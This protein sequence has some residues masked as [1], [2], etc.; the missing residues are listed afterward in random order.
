MKF[1][2]YF[3]IIFFFISFMLALA[4]G[5][6]QAVIYLFS[7]HYGWLVVAVAFISLFSAVLAAEAVEASEG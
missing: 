5:I 3:L 4:W 6:A 7:I 2:K 1:I